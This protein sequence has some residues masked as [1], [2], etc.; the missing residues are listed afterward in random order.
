MKYLKITFWMTL[1]SLTASG[2]S[3]EK[4]PK[5]IVIGAGIAGLTTAYHLQESGV[6]VHLY[7]ARN[8]VGG[9]ILTAKVKG[10]TAELGAQNIADGGESVHLNHLIDTFKLELS[11]TRVPVNH[12]YFTGQHLIPVKNILQEQQIDPKTLKSK[13]N[14]LALTASNIKE[15]LEQ[16]VEPDTSLYKILSVRMAAY[17]GGT[18]DQLSPLYAETLFHMMLGGVCSVHQANPEEDNS[19]DLVSIKGGNSLLCEKIQERLGEKIHLNMPLMNVSKDQ[20]GCFELIFQNGAAVKADIL[21]LAIPCSVYQD[22]AFAENVIPSQKLNAIRNI[23]YGKNAK[24]VVPFTNPLPKTTG[25]VSDQIIAF[26][27]PIEHA[28]TVY[29]TGETSLFSPSTITN[30]YAGVRPMIEMWFG[31]DCPAFTPPEYAEDKAGLSYDT[32]VGY[33][34]PNDPYARGTYSYI[35]SG[36]EEL[37]TSQQTHQGETFKAL[38]APIENTLYFAGE[39]ASL[40]I[41]VPGTMEAACES[42]ERIA[43]VITKSLFYK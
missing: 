37:L 24:I 4:N 31:Q 3:L 40:L 18:P 29:Y 25:L 22:I 33:S 20:E 6:D 36:Q 5:V 17:E 14:H 1:M 12:S 38:F 16:L 42:G 39:H 15:M 11:S 10:R 19:I 30:A 34:W 23:Q 28:L 32:P 26:F 27:D 9:R 35:A 43:R 8:R 21:V 13:L 41:E 7:E 2:F